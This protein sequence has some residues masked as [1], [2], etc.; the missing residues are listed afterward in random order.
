MNVGGIA[1]QE[2]AT[3]AEPIGDPMVH[4]VGREPVHA[5]DPDPHPVDDA[6]AHV[7]PRQVFRLMFGVRAHGADEPRVPLL[8]QREDGEK[9]GGVQSDVHLAVHGRSTGFYVSDV[10]QV[11]VGSAGAADLQRLAYGG[12]R[13]VASRK[14]GGLA[15]VHGSI[16]ASQEREH[17]AGPFCGDRCVTG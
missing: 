9:I 16:R 3:L 13:A 4:V 11:G 6:P 5:L 2:R 17:S 10:E 15:R 7:A 8:F 14:V 12:T 1:E